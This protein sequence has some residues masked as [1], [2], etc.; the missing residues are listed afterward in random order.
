MA[1][2]LKYM[3]ETKDIYRMR[4]TYKEIYKLSRKYIKYVY[5]YITNTLLRIHRTYIYIRNVPKSQS[6]I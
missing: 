2:I 5:I 4:R 6:N 1:N 3:V